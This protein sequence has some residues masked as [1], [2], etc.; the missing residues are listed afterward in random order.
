MTTLFYKSFDKLYTKCMITFICSIITNDT[1]QEII[2]IVL[3]CLEALLVVFKFLQ[4]LVEPESK[5]GKF[6]SRL[7]KGITFV[8]GEVKT[9]EKEISDNGEQDRPEANKPDDDGRI[10]D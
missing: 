1:I 6:L 7:L 5:F 9:I 10:G 8:K 3:M 4:Y 2:G